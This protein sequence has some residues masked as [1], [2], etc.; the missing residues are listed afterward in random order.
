MF[1]P[2][3]SSPSASHPGVKARRGPGSAGF[4]VPTPWGSA[5]SAPQLLPETPLPSPKKRPHGASP[6]HPVKPPRGAVVGGE[7]L[8]VS[9]CPRYHAWLPPASGP[10]R[11]GTAGFSGG[12]EGQ[13]QPHVSV[14]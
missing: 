13:T 4:A 9:Q 7:S 10:C 3:L 14:H 11:D 8:E 5:D 6:S 12:S 2:E 1:E